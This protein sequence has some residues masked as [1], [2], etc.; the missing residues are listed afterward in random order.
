MRTLAILAALTVALLAQDPGP[1]PD[2]P[3]PSRPWMRGSV[4]ISCAHPNV[5]KRLRE[6][7]PEARIEDCGHCKHQCDDEE[8]HEQSKETDG[9]YP[10]DHLCKARCKATQTTPGCDCPSPCENR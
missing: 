9:R 8:K 10:W 1:C 4:E 3:D 2:C 7:F 5:V 6:K